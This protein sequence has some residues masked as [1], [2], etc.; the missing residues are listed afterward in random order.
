VACGLCS[1]AALVPC[2]CWW[3]VRVSARVRGLPDFGFQ[4]YFLF[5]NNQAVGR[6]GGFGSPLAATRLVGASSRRL[7]RRRR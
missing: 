2:V 3:Y 4:F 1:T 5:N 7:R 6:A